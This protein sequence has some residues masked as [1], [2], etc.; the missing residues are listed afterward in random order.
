[1]ADQPKNSDED[2]TTTEEADILAQTD[3][4]NP[5][6]VPATDSSEEQTAEEDA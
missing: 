1:M 3:G 6:I 4:M 5:H 2:I